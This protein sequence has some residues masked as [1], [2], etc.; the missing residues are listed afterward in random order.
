MACQSLQSVHKLYS[1][2]RNG[3]RYI[4]ICIYIHVYMYIY[5]HICINIY[6]YIHIYTGKTLQ[7]ISFLAYTIHVKKC[8]GPHLV[9]VPLSVLFNW[10]AE[11]K[12]W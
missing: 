7:S 5:I 1:S 4:Y 11:F 2:G 12:R 10:M 3:L 9:V 8:V 6:I